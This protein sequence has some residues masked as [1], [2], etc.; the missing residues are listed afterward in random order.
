MSSLSDAVMTDTLE[1]VRLVYVHR[2]DAKWHNKHKDKGEPAVFCGW[3]WVRKHAEAGPFKSRSAA[4]RDAWYRYVAKRD[5]PMTTH[6]AP[7][8]SVRMR[9]ISTPAAP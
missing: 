2:T 9:R 3:Y 5:A 8:A 7:R 6:P 1:H 4:A